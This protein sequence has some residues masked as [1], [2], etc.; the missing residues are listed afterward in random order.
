M[1][2]I[3]AVGISAPK[4]KAT[5]PLRTEYLSGGG[6]MQV[7]MGANWETHH[8]HPALTFRTKVLSLSGISK[9]M[10]VRTSMM[11]DSG[12]LTLGLEAWQKKK[13]Y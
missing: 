3:S 9:G 13:I 4:T 6:R 8:C 5:I 1:G 10:V 12:M 2:S 7:W 11:A